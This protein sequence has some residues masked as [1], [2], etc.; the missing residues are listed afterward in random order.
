MIQDAT[1]EHNINLQE[2]FM[3]GDKSADILAGKNAGVTTILVEGNPDEYQKYDVKPNH[4]AKN[5]LDALQ[6]IY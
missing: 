6:Y 3:I 4:L 2:S 5:L 1:K